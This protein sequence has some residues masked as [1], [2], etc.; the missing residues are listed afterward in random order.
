MKE[1]LKPLEF[2]SNRVIASHQAQLLK[3]SV[4]YVLAKLPF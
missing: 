1:N 3:E 2:F 4:H